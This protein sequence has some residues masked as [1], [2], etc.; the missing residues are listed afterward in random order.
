MKK[1]FVI[2]FL[3]AAAFASCSQNEGMESLQKVSSKVIH[4]K[5]RWQSGKT[6]KPSML[7]RLKMWP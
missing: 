7:L 6:K 4:H 2:G 3:V 5:K 1:L